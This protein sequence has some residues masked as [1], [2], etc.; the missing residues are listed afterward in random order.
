MEAKKKYIK[1]EIEIVKIDT[2]IS[3]VMMTSPPG[4]PESKSTHQQRKEKDR[5]RDTFESPFE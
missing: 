4:D 5:K 3:L 1:P 2:E